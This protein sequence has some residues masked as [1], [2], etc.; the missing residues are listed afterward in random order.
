MS[1]KSFVPYWSGHSGQGTLASCPSQEETRGQ[2]ASVA[3]TGFGPL[4]G[5]LAP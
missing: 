4:A 2:M 5:K 1:I 3:A